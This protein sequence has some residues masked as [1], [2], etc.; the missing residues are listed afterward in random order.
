MERIMTILNVEIPDELLEPLQ[1]LARE[2][3]ISLNELIRDVLTEYVDDDYVWDNDPSP[4]EIKQLVKEAITDYEAGNFQTLD[5]FLD[6]LDLSDTE[7]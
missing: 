2:H 1:S 7:E 3:N 4:E 5:E 6:E